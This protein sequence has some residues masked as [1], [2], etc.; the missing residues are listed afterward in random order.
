[1]IDFLPN[2]T[3]IG[4]TDTGKW[5]FWYYMHDDDEDN[6]CVE[7]ADESFEQFLDRVKESI[8]QNPWVHKRNEEILS[9]NTVQ[10]QLPIPSEEFKKYIAYQQNSTGLLGILLKD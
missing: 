3:Y 9:A 10:E 5:G 1:M 6:P 7:Q 8:E 2:N 4:K